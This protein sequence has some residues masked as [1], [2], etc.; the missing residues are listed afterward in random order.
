[1][2]RQQYTDPGTTA[3][4]AEARRAGILAR[5][6][7][8]GGPVRGADL[9][10]E[11]DVSR[12]VIVSDVAILRAEGQP[13][14]GTPRGY[15]LLDREQPPGTYAVL[16]CKHDR[17]GTRA[18]LTTMVDHGL[19]VLDVI[20]EHPL[21]GE[22]RGNLMISSRQDVERFLRALRRGETE[23]LSSLTGGVHLHTVVAPSSEALE[24]ARAALREAG[25]LLSSSRP[26]GARAS[27]S[28]R[29]PRR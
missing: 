26:G 29:S 18:E 15:L 1:M 5:L 25:F 3:G 14:V 27:P 28:T 7:S 17:R 24:R 2:T 10:E 21:Y 19:T 20:V 11:F 22:L 4:S 9:A 23:L 8:V 6:R 16:A 12:Q 13:I